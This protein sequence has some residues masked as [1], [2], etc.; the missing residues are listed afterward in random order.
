MVTGLVEAHQLCG[1]YSQEADQECLCSTHSHLF[2]QCWS[3]KLRVKT[4]HDI[5]TAMATASL[6]GILAIP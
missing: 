1:I 5:Y 6:F 2:I 4:D 3:L